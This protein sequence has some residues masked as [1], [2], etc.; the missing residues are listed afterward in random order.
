VGELERH[1]GAPADPQQDE[2]LPGHTLDVLEKIG[3]HI[4]DAGSRSVPAVETS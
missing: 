2:R 4:F 3:R 1:S